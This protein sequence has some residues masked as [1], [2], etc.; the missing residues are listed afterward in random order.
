[1][2]DEGVLNVGG[3]PY[4][5]PDTQFYGEDVLDTPPAAVVGTQET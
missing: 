2:D 1:M 4:Y 3:P 5:G